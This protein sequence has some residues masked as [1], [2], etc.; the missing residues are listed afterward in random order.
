MQISGGKVF[1]EEG[2]YS[3]KSLTWEGAWHVHGITR[4]PAWL[5]QNE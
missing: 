5:G 4:R 2:P 1:Q 3:I